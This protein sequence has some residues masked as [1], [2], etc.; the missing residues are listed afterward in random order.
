MAVHKARQPSSTLRTISVTRS[1]IEIASALP[2]MRA[3]AFSAVIQGER[4]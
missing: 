3:L 1:R 2:F 4:G